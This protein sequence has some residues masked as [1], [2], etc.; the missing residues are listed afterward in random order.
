MLE[1][2]LFRDNVTRSISTFPNLDLIRKTYLKELQ[3]FKE[4]MYTSS[5]RVNNNNIL[6]KAM[7]NTLPSIDLPIEEYYSYCKTNINF[8]KD[9][10]GFVT[11]SST[12]KMFKNNFYTKDSIDVFRLIDKGINLVKLEDWK[13]LEIIKVMYTNNTSINFYSYGLKDL[14]DF[15]KFTIFEIDMMEL[16]IAYR[17]WA[18]DREYLELDIHPS[19]FLATFVYPKVWDTML[20]Y[21][22]L[23]R[24]ISSYQNIE[25]GPS[26]KALPYTIVDYEN[27][28]DKYLKDSI[29]Y[30]RRNKLYIDQ[31]LDNILYIKNKHTDNLYINGMFTSRSRWILWYS[32]LKLIYIMTMVMND[33]H[34]KNLNKVHFS[35]LELL[36]RYYRNRYLKLP[37]DLP[38]MQEYELDMY[39]EILKK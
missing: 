8:N 18:R 34:S 32:R 6:V 21:S 4:Y 37:D 25:I 2:F 31:I 15:D 12:G 16:L 5:L 30:I 9:L 19:R 35:R 22:I 23:N 26:K 14:E 27:K 39:V 1:Y 17:F 11:N 36:L 3:Y 29:K 24:F 20:D 10:I 28:V 33:N 7:L 13:S 38:S